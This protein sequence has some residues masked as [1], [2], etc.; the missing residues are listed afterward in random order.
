MNRY[1]LFTLLTAGIFTHFLPA[2]SLTEK[3][4]N[5]L[6][7][8]QVQLEAFAHRE[9]IY[10][11]VAYTDIAGKW[12]NQGAWNW[13]SGFPAG[14]MWMMYAHTG[15]EK[16][17]TYGRDWTESVRSRS[18]ATDN[19]TGFQIFCAYGY[20]LRYAGSVLSDEEKADYNSV[21]KTATETFTT[22]RYNNKVG[23]FR[24]WPA[25]ARDPY[26][27]R[28]E[29]NI[30]EMMNLELPAH[31][32]V[33]TNDAGLM[34]KVIS[35]ADTTWQN[36]IFKAQDTEWEDMESPEYVKR[37]LGSTWHV[38]GYDPETGRVIGKRTAQ[39]DKSESTWSRGQS[40]AVYGYA[41]IYRFTH[42]R[43]NIRFAEACFDYFM[44]ATKAQSNDSVPYSDFD[45]PVDKTH[46]KDTSAAAVV[47]S[48]AIELYQITK[49][50]KYKLAA[51]QILNDLTSPAYL[52][53]GTAYQSI[54]LKGS[55]EF[56][57][58]EE[59]G[60]IF[61]DFYFVEAMLRYRNLMKEIYLEESKAN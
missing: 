9:G 51:E 61:G 44:E 52:A 49:K 46:P 29:I 36:Q 14:L 41:M 34:E 2:Q 12:D 15:E 50:E 55:L 28:F 13:C 25:R 35:H 3:I 19:D 59:I 60:S 27:G 6:Q 23:G 42:E 7:F 43:R 18:I 57:R 40:W 11:F 21:L 5:A 54:L 4:D 48:A 26:R 16:W 38:V 20:G 17:A 45:A 32:A 58:K 22:Q 56:D 37:R 53:Q 47:A 8:S 31:V 24:S 39:G 33:T 1:A 30:D 10:R